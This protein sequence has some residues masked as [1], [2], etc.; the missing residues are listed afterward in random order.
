MNHAGDKDLKKILDALINQGSWKSEN[1][2]N[3]LLTMGFVL[4]L[5]W[6][7][8]HQLKIEDIPIVARFTD[9]EIAAAISADTAAGI[10]ACSQAM[11]NR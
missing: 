2:T 4:L 11:T 8:D 10:V 9:P 3:Y 5:Y 6:L 7:K 1:S